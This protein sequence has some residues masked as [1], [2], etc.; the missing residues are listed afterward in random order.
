MFPNAF[1]YFNTI[2]YN[3]NWFTITLLD[4]VFSLWP[5]THIDFRLFSLCFFLSPGRGE[6]T[7]PLKLFLF[8]LFFPATYNHCQEQFLLPVI[9]DTSHVKNLAS[10]SL[11]WASIPSHLSLP[12]CLHCTNLFTQGKW[13]L[14]IG[15]LALL[16]QKQ[17][18]V[19]IYCVLVFT[20]SAECLCDFKGVIT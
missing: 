18:F 9:A 17:D 2:K 14:N 16:V 10:P 8:G 13:F 11:Q 4:I 6:K 7:G 19:C 12:Q 1:K 3:F 20:A 15:V 5:S